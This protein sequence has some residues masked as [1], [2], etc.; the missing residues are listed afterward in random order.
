VW[1][2]AAGA[3]AVAGILLAPTQLIDPNMGWFGLKAFPA[4]VLGGFASVRGALVGG[5]LLGLVETQ[6]TYWQDGPWLPDGSGELAPWAVLLLCLI[7][8]PEGL[9]GEQLR[10]RA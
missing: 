9:F 1:A 2:V 8:R 7:L 3:A 6:A 4:A 10:K 5:V